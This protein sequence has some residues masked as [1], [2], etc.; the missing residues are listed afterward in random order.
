MNI[1]AGPVP[2]AATVRAFPARSAES[3]AKI[4]ER[5]NAVWNM[6]RHQ[7]FPATFSEPAR[8]AQRPGEV[9]QIAGH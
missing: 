7:A 2:R 6:D 4:A 3:S 5:I 9:F 1:P 8:P